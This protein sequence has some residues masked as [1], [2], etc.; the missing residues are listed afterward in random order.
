LENVPGLLN[1]NEKKDW[2]TVLRE[3][4]GLGCYH[5]EWRKLNTAQHGVPQNRPRIYIVCIHKDF[6]RKSAFKWPE[7]IERPSVERFLDQ[8][9]P[10]P[11]LLTLQPP[12]QLR[13]A[14]TWA[15]QMAKLL[16]DGEE[17]LTRPWLF[18]VGASEQR[19]NA[20]CDRCPCLLR[21]GGDIW[22]SS[23]GRPLNPRERCR[24]QGLNPDKIK[25][26]VSARQWRMQLG[27]TMSVNVL[28][29]L[30]SRLLPA[31]GLTGALPDRWA[32]GAAQTELEATVHID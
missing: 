24:L 9:G 1:V 25:V 29:R 23:H 28:E 16:R 12:P 22:I 4:E 10:K 11:T 14:E 8:L 32:S 27:N 20:M 2:R 6:Y 13:A 30:L 7:P 31:A 19:S 26:A 18:S 21:S 15:A 3:L 5:I 17:P